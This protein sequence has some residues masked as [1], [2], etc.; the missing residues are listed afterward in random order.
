MSSSTTKPTGARRSSHNPST[1]ACRLQSSKAG[2]RRVWGAAMQ[3]RES[4]AARREGVSI[5]VRVTRMRLLARRRGW[6]RLVRVEH[7]R[8]LGRGVGLVRFSSFVGWHLGGCVYTDLD[9][10]VCSLS[11][12]GWFLGY[13]VVSTRHVY[14][15]P[16]DL[17]C[18]IVVLAQCRVS[19]SKPQPLRP[20]DC[21]PTGNS[22]RRW[23]RPH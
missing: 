22:P 12:L 17:L 6:R 7:R 2:S 11:V 3:V 14:L 13:V 8:E 20:A 1:R 10:V 19:T 5:R 9:V 18:S 16:L 21:S 4:R 15:T 23:H